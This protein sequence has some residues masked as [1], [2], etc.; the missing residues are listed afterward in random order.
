[1]KKKLLT[2]TLAVIMLINCIVFTPK[3]EASTF[4]DVPDT[5]W[6]DYYIYA[7][8]YLNIINGYEDGTFKPDKEVKT[9]EFIKMAAL[10]F[11][12]N[13]E[14][15]P[16]EG[17]H[18]AMQYVRSLNFIALNKYDY[19]DKKLESLITRAEAANIVYKIYKLKNPDIEIDKTESYIKKYTDEAT[20][21]DEKVR[22]AINVCTQYGILNGFEDGSFGGEKTLTRAQAAKLICAIY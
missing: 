15:K 7:M 5:H 22:L 19:D 20:I 18:W 4:S 9:G 8:Q 21:T 6:A 2:I 14:G 11:W 16:K 3:V 10:A 17:E 1:M 13:Y 12:Y